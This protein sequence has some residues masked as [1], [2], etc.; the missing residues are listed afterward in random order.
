[1]L[2]PDSEVAWARLAHALARTDRISDCLEACERALELGDDPEVRD[3]REQ[4]PR[5]DAAGAARGLAAYVAVVRSSCSGS[6][7]ASTTISAAS[8]TIATNTAWVAWSR[9]RREPRGQQRA[10]AGDGEAAAHRAEELDRGG[11]DADLGHVDA[12]LGRDHERLEHRAHAEA[13]DGQV[14]RDDDPRGVARP[15]ARA[16]C[17]RRARGCCRG[18]GRPCSGRSARCTGR[19]RSSPAPS[20]SESGIST[21]PELVALDPEH[22][23]D[24]DRH[25]DRDP[26]QHAADQQRGGGRDAERAA[27]EQTE[28]EQRLGHAA[29]DERERREADDADHR[30]GDH[31]GR[32][33]RVARP[34]P[35]AGEQDRGHAD[36]QRQRA[37]RSR[38]VCSRGTCW[39]RIVR[40]TT[41]SASEPERQV[42]QEDPAPA[43]ACR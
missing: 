26:E 16:G 23:L 13:D 3:L 36:A 17:S 35:G 6:R 43:R 12:V 14:E 15:A 5:L 24:V 11:G 37:R 29:L 39:M 4:V 20:R 40:I 25:V 33:P 1:M 18:S 8:G 30:R 34:A 10:E 28:R 27:A 42:D 7:N 22:A 21:T 31:L 38:C 2:A 32:V 9:P 19:R 41:T